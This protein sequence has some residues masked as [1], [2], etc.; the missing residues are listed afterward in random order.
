MCEGSFPLWFVFSASDAN[1]RRYIAA[2]VRLLFHCFRFCTPLTYFLYTALVL[3]CTT[4][5]IFRKRG[6]NMSLQ[7][8][9]L[10]CHSSRSSTANISSGCCCSLLT[11]SDVINVMSYMSWKRSLKAVLRYSTQHWGCDV[12]KSI[13]HVRIY[14]HIETM[15]RHVWRWVWLHNVNMKHV[16]SV[17][18]VPESCAKFKVFA[19]SLSLSLSLRALFNDTVSC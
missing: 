12:S 11:S 6:M 3:V 5:R 10:F 1:K 19:L 16:A 2:F 17:N 4:K 7:D 8:A 14:C 9:T 15:E 13:F 18:Y